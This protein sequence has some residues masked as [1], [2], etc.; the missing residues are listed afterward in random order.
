M[1]QFIILNETQ[2]K[3]L[4]GDP[5]ASR[6]MAGAPW[7]VLQ[8]MPLVDGARYVLSVSLLTNPDFTEARGQLAAFPISDVSDDEFPK[9]PI[10]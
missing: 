2:A 5:F 6:Q 1:A 7:A 9:A 3:A 4:C 10:Q 8:P